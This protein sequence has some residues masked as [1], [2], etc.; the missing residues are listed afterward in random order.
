[1]QFIL[2]VSYIKQLGSVKVYV[3]GTLI[4]GKSNDIR[5]TV[6]HQADSSTPYYMLVT[7]YIWPGVGVEPTRSTECRDKEVSQNLKVRESI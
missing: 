6:D 4:Y 7:K 5:L 2:S 1:M 3:T